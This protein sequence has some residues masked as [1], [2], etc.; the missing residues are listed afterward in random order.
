MKRHVLNWSCGLVLASFVV[1]AGQAATTAKKSD[2]SEADVVR[3][4]AYVPM[5]D[6]TRIAYISYRPKT[7]RYPTVFFYSPYTGGATSFETAK[8]FLDAGYAFVGANFPATGCSEGVIDYW[9]DGFDHKVGRYGAEVVEWISR[10]PWSDENVGMIGNS[11]AG[12]L[13]VWVAA[14]QPPHLRAIV[15]SGVE[16]GYEDWLHLGGMMQLDSTA[17]WALNSEFGVQVRGAEWRISQGDKE[18]AAIRQSDKRVVKRSFIDEVRKH[19]LKD[20]WWESAYLAT[21]K[22]AGKV[23]VPTM[24]I[25]SWQDTYGGAARESTRL[26]TQLIP[27]VKHKKLVLMNGDHGIAGPGP[28]GY[29]L[30]DSERMKFLDRWV[31]GV[32]NGVDNELPVTVFWDVREPNGDAKKSVA[33]WVTHHKTWPEP[34][35]ER[36]PY[37][38]T[39]DAKIS[40]DKPADRPTEGPRAYIYPTGAELYG[41]NQQFA[42]QPYSK[43][44]LN[45]R[46]APAASDMVLLGNP[47]VTLYLSI[48]HG[49]DADLE[50]TLKD[51]DPDGN[52]LFLQSGLLRTSLRA[53]DE[54]RSHADEVVPL[55]RKFEKLVPGNIYEVRMSLLSP[56]AHVVRQGHSIELTIGAP[57][58]IP[59]PNIGSIPAGSPSINRVYHSEKYPS[60]ILLPVIPGAVAQAPA[61]EC[62]TLRAQPCRKVTEFVPGGLP[63]Q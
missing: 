27:D 63:I 19:P 32:E 24:L 28:R 50:L 15:A 1:S 49:D 43:G 35:V 8:E 46:T 17:G 23:N 55:F 30:V 47:E 42:I 57:N 44:V 45:Y 53:V 7:G 21:A 52:V 31:K 33:G 48:D 41:S 40:P 29:S 26:F 13:Q 51:V 10:Q 36:R 22:V 34:T 37:Y 61:P 38:L 16:D 2:F 14:E 6:G 9:V 5:K 18:C 20:E 56:I 11:S 4:I 59:H 12:T 58:P 3:D 62:G 54:A 25:A 39:A 60:K